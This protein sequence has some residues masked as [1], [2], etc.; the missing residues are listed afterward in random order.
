MKKWILALIILCILLFISILFLHFSFCQRLIVTKIS[1]YIEKKYEFKISYKSINYNLINL[2]IQLKDIKLFYKNKKLLT[3]EEGEIR[4]YYSVLWGNYYSYKKVHI[5][6]LTFSLDK[7]NSWKSL[8]T[9]NNSSNKNVPIEFRI[10][11]LDIADSKINLKDEVIPFE[12]HSGDINLKIKRI[13]DNKHEGSIIADRINLNYRNKLNLILNFNTNFKIIDSNIEI[14]KMKVYNHELTASAAGKIE[15]FPKLSLSLEGDTVINLSILRE[16][17]T[18][19]NID[20]I[21]FGKL[22]INYKDTLYVANEFSIKDFAYKKISYPSIKGNF[23]VEY[24]EVKIRDLEILK[25]GGRLSVLFDYSLKHKNM[26]LEAKWSKFHL[27]K[28]IESFFIPVK[29]PLITD[30]NLFF[31]GGLDSLIK[32]ESVLAARMYSEKN[33]EIESNIVANW[34]KDKVDFKQ[35]IFEAPG[36]YFS[37]NDAYLQINKDNINESDFTVE[38]NLIISDYHKIVGFIKNNFALQNVLR[39]INLLGDIRDLVGKS[40]ISY[41][42]NLYEIKRASVESNL[43]VSLI[44]LNNVMINIKAGVNNNIVNIDNIKLIPKEDQLI[45]AN[46]NIKLSKPLWN[47]PIK[48]NLWGEIK[49][50]EI[51][52]FAFISSFINKIKAKLSGNFSIEGVADNYIIRVNYSSNDL[53]IMDESFKA[54]VGEARISSDSTIYFDNLSVNKDGLDASILG[55][56][57]L[58]NEWMN[59]DINIGVDL[60][61]I[62]IIQ[63]NIRSMN[64]LR[65][66][67]IE[68]VVDYDKVKGLISFEGSILGSFNNLNG[69]VRCSGERVR[70]ASAYIGDIKLDTILNKSVAHFVI[71]ADT[72]RIDGDIDINK[73]LQISANIAFTDSVLFN[74]AK[75]LLPDLKPD[76]LMTSNIN[77]NGYLLEPKTY[78]LAAS[79]DKFEL[80]MK[81]MNLIATEPFSIQYSDKLISVKGAK[82]ESGNSFV[83]VDGVLPFNEE[84]EANMKIMGE[85]DGEV[86]QVFSPLI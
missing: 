73:S 7:E 45:I 54:I 43:V 9:S 31:K 76:L 21:L 62:S 50:I 4:P 63:D 15:I 11:K 42:G 70:I 77:F 17:L 35:L 48:Y 3:L 61:K 33:K 80:G 67:N 2:K 41:Y 53:L 49:D 14:N 85:I 52:K 27:N 55:K 81:E 12:L 84:E 38:S 79:V 20:G 22:N 75:D 18:N 56:Y 74:I 44:D 47:K 24:P 37:A 71:N 60:S 6:K 51:N 19:D 36:V 66:K 32:N 10:D 30:G 23:V 69:T 72:M 40:K 68:N 5:K 26:V 64:L 39:A 57:N 59:F 78:V 16:F 34:K 29:E 1:G 13:K 46:G 58:K 28:I 82:I 25:G 83:S 8:F 86:V 65:S